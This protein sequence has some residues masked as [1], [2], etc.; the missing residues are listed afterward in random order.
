ME[1]L[2]EN[3]SLTDVANSALVLIGDTPVPSIYDS[4][5]GRCKAIRIL[6]EQT[7][8]EVQCHHTGCWDELYREELLTPKDMGDKVY[9][10][11]LRM[12]RVDGVFDEKG[13]P[14][15]WRIFGREL[16]AKRRAKTI[17]YLAYSDNPGEWS[18][19]LKS[20]VIG[21]LSAKLVASVTKDFST[22]AQLVERFWAIEFP[23]WAGNKLAS[24]AKTKRGDDAVLRREY[25]NGGGQ[26]LPHTQKYY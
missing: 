18:P 5:D 19:E 7:I 8:R 25:P 23:R 15:E 16:H 9:N 12:L 6:T 24:A 13:S 22:S 4:N 26:V 11:P 3:A 17:R 1:P 10:L 21:L 2:N 20:A 14:V